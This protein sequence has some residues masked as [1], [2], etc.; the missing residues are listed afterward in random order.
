MKKIRIFDLSFDKSYRKKFN[1][2]S[3]KILD[4]GFL[5]NH[6]Y[7]KNL[8]N[9]FSNF[10]GSKFCAGTNSGTS[11]IEIILRS[12]NI[13]KKKV[14]IGTNTFVATGIAVTSAGGFPVPVDIDKKYFSL[15]YA[16]LKK[17]I[18][19]KIGAVI[20]IHIGGLVTPDIIKISKLCKKFKVPL[21][22][23]CAQAFGSEYKNKHV[24]NFGIAGAFSL[25]TT[26]VLTAG[27]GGL[28]TTNDKNFYNK[29]TRNR[30]HGFNSNNKLIYDLNGSNFRMS[31]FVAL[32]ALCD[33][34]RVKYRIKKRSLI[35]KKYQQRL[36]DTKWITLSPAKNTTTSYYKQIILS[37]IDRKILQEKLNKK[38]IS[39]TGG[40]YYKPLHRQPCIGKFQEKKFPVANY[41]ADNHFCPPC[42]P[43]L[44][45]KDIDYI[46][47]VLLSIR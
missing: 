3:K 45:I 35:A 4:N 42:Y 38:K 16:E 7:V 37:P 20:I 1:L 36:K 23:D 39:M 25:Q 43:E 24:G 19:K 22:E 46:C 14:L 15:S 2:G 12:L 30:E 13:K 32:A 28:V 18:N 10:T 21:I 34:S 27:E 9:K 17:K 47:D 29:V 6:V 8:E 31:E 11:A 44:N 33:M 5:T 40:V 26:K 41:F